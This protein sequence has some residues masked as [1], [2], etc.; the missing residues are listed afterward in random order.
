MPKLREKDEYEQLN[1]K[2]MIREVKMYQAVCDVCGKAH[3]NEFL[4]YCAWVDESS[5]VEDAYEE[6]WTEIDDKLY[7]PDCYEYDEETDEYKPKVK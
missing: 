7:C 1:S 4:G 2:K 3:V 5:A 6:G